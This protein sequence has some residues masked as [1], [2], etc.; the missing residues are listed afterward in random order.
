MFTVVHRSRVGFT[1]I[2]LLVVIAIIALLAA[3]LFPVFARAREKAR[4]TTCASNQ[5]QLGLGFIQY[6]QDYDE[7]FPYGNDGFASTAGWARPIMPYLKAPE[8]FKCPNDPT[9]YTR[10]GVQWQTVSYALNDSLLPDG[11]R[12]ANW[13][14]SPTPLSKL[15]APASTVMLCEA[16]GATLDPKRTGTD[17]DF[18]GGATMSTQ[19]WTQDGLGHP[20][21]YCLYAT[22]NPVGHTLKQAP[23]ITDGV[24]SGGSNYLAADGHV[25]WLKATAISPGKD[26]LGSN[27]PQND[28]GEHASGTSYMNVNGGGRGSATMTFSKI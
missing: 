20:S 22:G 15:V 3:I 8:A 27:D 16:F 24:H 21:S 11:N 13:N 2:E 17:D 5:K 1:L 6:V 7:V 14:V 4:Q 23:G 28:A 12:D 9:S 25:R 26:A 19:F 18:S 10:D